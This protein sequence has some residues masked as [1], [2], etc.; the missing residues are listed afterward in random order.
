MPKATEPAPYYTGRPKIS[1][2][3][4]RTPK[5]VSL[6]NRLWRELGRQ[7]HPKGYRSVSAM[8]E[9]SIARILDKHAAQRGVIDE[10]SPKSE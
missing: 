7:Y 1:D 8:I 4:R 2:D 6:P 3:D 9:H 5:S 10:F